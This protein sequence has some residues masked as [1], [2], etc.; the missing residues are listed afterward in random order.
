MYLC[1]SYNKIIPLGFAYDFIVPPSG[2]GESLSPLDDLQF[3]PM[4]CSCQKNVNKYDT[5]RDFIGVYITG[6]GL[7]ISDIYQVKS[8]A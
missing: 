4:T 5:S 2:V 7:C 6:F 8:M 1:V 3:S